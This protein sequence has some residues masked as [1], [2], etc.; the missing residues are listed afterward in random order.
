MLKSHSRILVFDSGVGGLSVFEEVQRQLPDVELVFASDSDGFPYGIR[1][2]P[3]LIARVDLVL[4]K[5]ISAVEPDIAIIACNSAST[6]VLPV[7]RSK[8][9][10]PFIGVVPA[11]KPA[12]ALSISR[13]IGLIATPATISRPYT[14]QLI[15]EFA[16]GCSVEMLGSSELVY[17]AEQKLR[18]KPAPVAK[19][20]EIIAPLFADSTGPLLDT[21]VLA[22]THFPLLKEELE[23]AAPR[24]VQWIDSAD[25]IARRAQS[26]LGSVD[27]TANTLNH[28]AIFTG[29]A[30][31]EDKLSATLKKLGVG[32]ISNMD[33]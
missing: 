28:R 8:F 4:S 19:V 3:D 20:A 7:I 32:Q 33:I 18:G 16:S 2:E 17:L 15:D 14:R 5:L 25:A 11:I 23:K 12:A 10:I 21:I 6:V 26:L 9:E 22:C 1:S 24:K 13:S 29:Q 30:E 31:L 27:K